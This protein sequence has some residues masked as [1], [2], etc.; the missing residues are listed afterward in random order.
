MAESLNDLK[1]SLQE[2]ELQTASGDQGTDHLL[3]RIEW[4]WDCLLNDFE[5][6]FEEPGV[7]TSKIL[8]SIVTVLVNIVVI[9]T[10]IEPIL[11]KCV[12]LQV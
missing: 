7:F 10:N 8:A 5:S 4:I 9:L 3:L 2:L 1:N 11:E 12:H 6:Y